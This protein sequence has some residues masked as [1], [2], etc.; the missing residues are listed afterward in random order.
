MIYEYEYECVNCGSKDV[1]AMLW[2][3]INKIEP[4]PLAV[5]GIKEGAAGVA[6]VDASEPAYDVGGYDGA[7]CPTCEDHVECHVT[8]RKK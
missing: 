2:V 5:P 1:L 4:V 3:P 7:W 8:E 6:P